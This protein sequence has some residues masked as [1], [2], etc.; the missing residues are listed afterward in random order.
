MSINVKIIMY[1]VEMFTLSVSREDFF[2]E[3]VDSRF[4]LISLKIT[5]ADVFVKNDCPA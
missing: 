1:I 3:H 2:L 5:N 4:Q